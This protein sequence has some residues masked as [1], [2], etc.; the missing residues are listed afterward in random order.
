MVVYK[1]RGPPARQTLAGGKS[2]MKKRPGHHIRTFVNFFCARPGDGYPCLV[3]VTGSMFSKEGT[4]QHHYH[5]PV[6]GVQEKVT[7]KITSQM[8]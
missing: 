1:P 7:C 2:S 5:R 8:F 4:C 3:S 6:L